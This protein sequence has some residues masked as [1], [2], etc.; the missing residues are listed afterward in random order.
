MGF[1][2][3]DFVEKIDGEETKYS[4]CFVGKNDVA[5]SVLREEKFGIFWFINFFF[6]RE[7]EVSNDVWNSVWNPRAKS[8][9]MEV[10]RQKTNSGNFIP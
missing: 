4:L 5:N 3:D 8:L 9:R 2:G 1:A 6:L 7:N 10:G